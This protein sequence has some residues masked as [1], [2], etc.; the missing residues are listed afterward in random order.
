MATSSLAVAR[1]VSIVGYGN[2]GKLLAKEV[3]ILTAS[4]PGEVKGSSVASGTSSPAASS[5]S[6]KILAN[7][8]RQTAGT[9]A[10]TTQAEPEIVNP[11][12][13]TG[14]FIMEDPSPQAPF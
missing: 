8:A 10:T 3:T 13:A 9:P 12:T 4:E 5:T 14:S 1:Q 11:N 6:P 7:P 2:D